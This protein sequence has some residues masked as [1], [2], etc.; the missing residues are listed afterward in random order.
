MI[1]IGANYSPYQFAQYRIL[2]Y[3]RYRN[4]AQSFPNTIPFSEGIGFIDR[5]VNPKKDIDFAY[6]V[7]AHE[8]GH[9]WWGHQ[10][11]GGDVQGSNMMSEALAE[12][13]ALRIMEH[14]YGD[15]NMRLFLKHE[16]DGYL[17]GRSGEIRHEPPLA[18]VQRE[19]YVWYQKGGHH[20]LRARRLYRRRQAQPRARQLPHV[21]TATPM[22]I[23]RW[24]PPT[25]PAVPPP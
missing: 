3:P 23:I 11:I 9:Q 19:P 15:D 1:T 22:P 7:T 10:L 12:Y 18:L 14:K 25:T 4:F 24:T 13:S 5:L 20:P 21:S 17:R 6:F 2:E 16:L 8:L